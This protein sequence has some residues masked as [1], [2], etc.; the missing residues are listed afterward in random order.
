[1]HLSKLKKIQVQESNYHALA[2]GI[3][4]CDESTIVIEFFVLL[5][6]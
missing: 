4:K 2:S 1:M 3:W 6:G 5:N